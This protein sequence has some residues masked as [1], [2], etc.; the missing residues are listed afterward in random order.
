MKSA[1]SRSGEHGGLFLELSGYCKVLL[2]SKAPDSS[3]WL[4][5]SDCSGRGL[6]RQ[7]V[8]GDGLADATGEV[9]LSC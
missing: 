9:K 8:L 3:W 6:K 5:W 2:L 4:P 1:E 7:H